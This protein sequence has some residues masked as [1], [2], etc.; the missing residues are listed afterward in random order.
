MAASGQVTASINSP[1]ILDLGK[2]GRKKIRDLKQGQ[3]KLLLDIEDALQEVARSLGV[4]ATEKQLIPVV[5]IYRKKSRKRRGGGGL[6]P[7]F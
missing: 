2:T 3:G 1:V 4:E 7:F 6:I 5:L